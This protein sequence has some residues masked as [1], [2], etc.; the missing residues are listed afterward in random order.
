[1]ASLRFL[2]NK[3]QVVSDQAYPKTLTLLIFALA[4]LRSWSSD[5]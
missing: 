4:V 2:Y 3:N 5:F 1:M